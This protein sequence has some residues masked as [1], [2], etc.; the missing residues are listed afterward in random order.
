MIK[1]K[2]KYR[3]LWEKGES[4]GYYEE[5]GKVQDIMRKRGSMGYD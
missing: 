3:I 1:R 4:I 5:K 2:G